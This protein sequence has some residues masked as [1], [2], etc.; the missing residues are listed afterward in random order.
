MATC[1][2][3]LAEFALKQESES[4]PRSV[5]E[6]ANF[7][8]GL[9]N[10]TSLNFIFPPRRSC[11]RSVEQKVPVA[12]EFD[13]AKRNFSTVDCDILKQQTAHSSRSRSVSLRP[14][15]QVTVR[16]RRLQLYAMKSTLA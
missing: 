12:A 14:D 2:E 9:K 4:L 8:L 6:K 15:W 10:F 1:T 13:R 7:L 3:V 16:D 5:L 11:G